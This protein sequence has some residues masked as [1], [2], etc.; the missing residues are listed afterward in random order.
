MGVV[1]RPSLV[2]T[3]SL[4]LTLVALLAAPARA[5]ASARHATGVRGGAVAMA[6]A[7]EPD[8]PADDGTGDSAD[9]DQPVEGADIIPEPNSGQ[10][11][12]EAGD[13]GGALQILVLVLIVAGVGGIVAMFVRESRR[14]RAAR[15]DR[16]DQPSGPYSSQAS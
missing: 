1:R 2:V 13:R 12:Q 11:P 7:Q 6:P 3:I 4:V 16:R 15:R 8:A 9:E 10:Q 5:G 14:N